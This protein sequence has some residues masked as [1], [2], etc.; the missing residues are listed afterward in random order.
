[1]KPLSAAWHI[2]TRTQSVAVT[3]AEPASTTSASRRNL[4]SGHLARITDLADS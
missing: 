1:M 2:G 4:R 3:M